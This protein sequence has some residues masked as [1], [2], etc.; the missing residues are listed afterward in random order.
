MK[1]ELFYKK[2][3]DEFTLLDFAIIIILILNLFL[4]A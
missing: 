2:D 4:E 1:R 3:L